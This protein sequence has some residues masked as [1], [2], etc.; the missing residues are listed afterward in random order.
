MV[1]SVAHF[2]RKVSGIVLILFFFGTPVWCQGLQPQP[3]T[4]DAPAAN[5]GETTGAATPA[6][7]MGGMDAEKNS[8]H[9]FRADLARLERNFWFDQKQI[10]TSPSK[11]RFSDTV[12]L[13]PIL[14]ITAGLIQT[15]G[16]YSMHLSQNPSTTSRYN[17]ISNA[18]LGALLGGV[19]GMYLLSNFTHNDK[20]RETGLLSAEAALDSTI[21]V[22]V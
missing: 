20:W 17:T 15:D 13:V 8:D 18:G 5:G 1:R 16:T 9:P 10:Y 2:F 21:L 11:I 14:G 19:G 6:P 12:W 7:A 22:E 3:E 4:S